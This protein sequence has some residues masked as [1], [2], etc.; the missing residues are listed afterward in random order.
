[1]TK[2]IQSNETY[3]FSR[4]ASLPYDPEDILADFDCTLTSEDLQLPFFSGESPF[5]S[6]LRRRLYQSLRL[7][8]LTIKMAYR[9]VDRLRPAALA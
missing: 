8:D 6:D 1:M 5:L 4:Y 2:V 7:V 9:A 3:T